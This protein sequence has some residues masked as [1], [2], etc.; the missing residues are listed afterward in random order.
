MELIEQ[1]KVSEVIKDCHRKAGGNKDSPFIKLVKYLKE[2]KDY[3]NYR[4][5]EQPGLPTG[6]GIVESGHKHALQCRLKKPGT[7]LGEEN[8]NKMCALTASIDNEWW[9]EF[10]KWK[11]CNA[12]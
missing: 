7:W 10:W 9:N 12:N 1:G 3:L 2:R 6:S 4:E 8:V 11:R 5:A